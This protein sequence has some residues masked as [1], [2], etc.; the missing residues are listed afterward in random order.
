MQV[1]LPVIGALIVLAVAED[2]FSTVLFPASGHGVIRKP[3]ARLVWTVFR[4]LADRTSGQRRRNLL[5]YSGPAQIAITLGI[6]FLLLLFGWACIYKPALGAGIQASKGPTDTGWGTAF[7]VSGYA[8]TTL[9]TGDVVGQDALYRILM[10][11]E[12][13][14]GFITFT[15]V[16]SYF[17]SVYSNLTPR[18]AFA[19]GLHDR[20]RGT[21]DAAE[22]IAGLAQGSELGDVKQELS[23]TASF[24]RRVSQTHRF[25]PVL[26]YFHYREPYYS[27]PRVL[28]TVLDAATLLKTALDEQ[29]YH[30]FL[31]SP[32]ADSVLAAGMSVLDELVPGASA[33]PPDAEGEKRWRRRYEQACRRLTDEGLAVRPDEADGSTAYVTLRARWDSKVVRLAG[34]MQHEWDDVQPGPPAV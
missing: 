13:A 18:N 17:L 9:G 19:Q 16:I 32:A 26:R 21:D 33:E 22:L 20:T 14:S 3:L 15:M 12:A 7:Y 6:W 5:S 29:H 4:G 24:L 11:A 1:V 10:I 27:L 2:V 34:S 25:Y 8:L 23:S 30:E 28:L 31:R